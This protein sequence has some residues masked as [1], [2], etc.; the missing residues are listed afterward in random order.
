VRGEDREV[1]GA[2]GV[3]KRYVDGRRR[4]DAISDVTLA[5]PPGVLW[6]L[7]GP[8]GSG[9]TTL[10]GLL[11][12]VIAPTSGELR[13]LGRRTSHLRDHHRTRLRREAVGLVF[14]EAAL[15]RGM[16]LRENVLLPLVPLGGPGPDHERRADALLDRFGLGALGRTRVERLSGGERQRGA[17]ARALVLAPP[18]LLLDEP[19]SH[20]DAAGARGIVDLLT[21][22]RAEGRAV[23]ATTHDPRLADDPRVDRILDLADGGLR[24]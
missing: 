11:G 1:A 10:L 2:T 20:V 24:T 17:I 9:K 23:L 12:G 14:Q 7:R 6:V 4:V 22:L 19:T 18:L 21:A 5:I 13:L 8:S 15:V 3:S 16:T